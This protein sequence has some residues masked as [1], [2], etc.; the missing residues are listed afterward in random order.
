M[1]ARLV[2]PRPRAYPDPGTMGQTKQQGGASTAG[3]A[4]ASRGG[5]PLMQEGLPFRS[6]VLG[7]ELQGAEL[8]GAAASTTPAEGEVRLAASVLRVT[9]RSADGAYCVLQAQS[10]SRGAVI[11]KAS[12]PPLHSGKGKPFPRHRNAAPKPGVF[13]AVGALGALEPGDC[14]QMRGRWE[15]HTKHGTQLRV[16]DYVPTLPQSRQG[17]VKYL[18]SGAITGVGPAIAERIV[19]TFGEKAL[20]VIE[21]ESARLQEIS[22]IGKQTA[23]R[24]GESARSRR[25]TLE[26]MSFL[27]GLGL[28]SAMA[29]RVV[30]RLGD[31]TVRRVHEDP[32]RLATLVHGIGFETS[33]QMGQRLGLA[34][35]DP[36]RLRGIVTHALRSAKDDGHT[37]L[38]QE[39]LIGRCE[40]LFGL[41]VQQAEGAL[42]ALLEKKRLVRETLGGGPPLV[43]LPTM[44]RAEMAVAL[45]L[46]A[47]KGPQAT[48]A[49]KPNRTHA[50]PK[51]S[52]TAV[53]ASQPLTAQQQAAVQSALSHRVSI[54]TGGP[55]TGK[56]TTV[57]GIVAAFE[58]KHQKLMLCAP[59]G[60]AA[61]RMS[62]TTGREALTLHRLLE[63]SPM[64]GGFKRR[65]DRPLEADAVLVDEASMVDLTLFDGL[66]EALAPTT[67]LILVGDVDQLPPIGAGQVLRELIRSGEIPCTR[68]DQVFRQA[69]HSA[70]VRGAHAILAGNIPEFPQ[71]EPTGDGDLY[72]VEARDSEALCEALPRVLTRVQQRYG[73]DPK[74]DIQVVSAMRRGKTGTDALNAQLQQWFVGTPGGTSGTPREPPPDRADFRVGDKVMQTRNDYDRDVY[75]GDLGEVTRVGPEVA[76]HFDGREVLYDARSLHSLSLAYACTVHKVQGS[77][78]PAVVVVVD[79]AQHIML[80]RSLMYTA[81]TRAR[82]LAIFV[83]NPA[84]LRRA[85]G[86]AEERVAF[87]GLRLRLST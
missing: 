48:P 63:W 33:D 27:M 79:P 16:M 40:Q 49:S 13:T 57:R 26:T 36:R 17:L 9:F 54:V 7:A 14:V 61:K 58:A 1:H 85:V 64:E 28:G 23:K 45:S 84:A 53:D 21:H 74:Q 20:D 4:S 35:D 59:T 60:R 52:K 80:T 66:M 73:L 77:E 37:C 65:R 34:Q 83:G 87:S 31:D 47:R 67:S 76:V 38:P 70:V 69:E 11:P 6:G 71:A 41:D 15:T 3:G 18:G 46:N 62:E 29:H 86:R 10:E 72:F 81:V 19:G 39:E 2:A 30:E 5:S 42:E 43:Y 12:P 56:T 78:F 22:G 8:L 44:H 24:I 68:L 50:P 32:Y 82:K 25:K 51:E 55:G 75:N